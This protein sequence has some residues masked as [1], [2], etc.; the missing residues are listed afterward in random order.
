LLPRDIQ[1]ALPG[2]FESAKVV[3][4]AAYRLVEFGAGSWI[5][6]LPVKLGH[7]VS[8]I[9]IQHEVVVSETEGTNVEGMLS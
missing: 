3:R 2:S 8:L 4:A 6:R 7:H 1:K 9:V 5:S